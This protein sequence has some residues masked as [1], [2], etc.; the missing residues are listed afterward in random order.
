MLVFADV[1]LP[2]P[3]PKPFTYEVPESLQANLM[4]G[5]RVV[6]PFGKNKFYTGLVYRIHNQTPVGYEAKPI[7]SV[8]ESNPTVTDYQF[9]LWEWITSYYLCPLGLIMKAALPSVL[10]LESQTILEKNEDE[11]LDWSALSEE[12][13]LL[14]EALEQGPLTFSDIMAITGKKAVMKSIGGLLAKNT[15]RLQQVLKD[16]YRPKL[17]KQLR[18]LPT[19]LQPSAL[20]TIFEQLKKAPKQ[21]E[22]LM[23][24]LSMHPKGGWTDVVD[25]QKKWGSTAAITQQLVK[26]SIFEKRQ[27]T[28]DRLQTEAAEEKGTQLVLTPP[29]KDAYEAIQ[30]SFERHSVVLLEGITGS[31]KT[32]VYMEQIRATMT[33]GK[34]VLYL[35]PEISL[36]TQIVA[37]L[38]AQFP[39][40]I[41]VFHSKFNPQERTEIWRHILQKDN[42]AQL[43]V[44]ARSAVLLPFQNL[45]LVIIDEEH[46]TAYKQ[47]DPAPRYHARDSA[48]VMAQYYKAKVLLGSATPSLESL[49]QVQKGKYGHVSL[50]QRYGGAQLPTIDLVDVKEA[51]RKKQMQLGMF[52]DTLVSAIA[53][54]LEKE[55]QVILFHNRR[56]YAPLLECRT[57][58]HIPQCTQCDVSLTYHQ[59]NPRMQC[60]YC[61]YQVPKPTECSACGTPHLM[62]KGT[63][64][65]QI[66]TALQ[67]L[68]PQARIGRMD[69]DSTRGKNDFDTLLASFA[70]GKIQVL[71]GTQMVVKGLDFKNVQLVG[72]INADQLINQ[73]DFRAFERS[74]QMLSQV[75]GRAGRSQTPGRVLIQ[76]Y[77]PNQPLLQHVKKQS[78]GAFYSSELL[79][80]KRLMYPPFGRLIRLTFKHRNRDLVEK[81]ALWFA[82]VI[83][84]SYTQPILGPAAPPIS[85]IQNHYLQQVLFKMTSPKDRKQLKLLL[86][87]TQRSFESIAQYR[88]VKI[89]MDVDPY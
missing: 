80:R 45:G 88:A 82:N 69:W 51:Y 66:E 83:R 54:V 86:V 60:H 89:N 7:D 40:R 57:C 5:Q 42:K 26:K 34:Q 59:F 1:I 85:R 70:T 72:V 25:L 87:K 32:A 65:Q 9:S 62:D 30:K 61:G 64:T 15:V 31:G 39:D 22:L 48:I 8:L 41:A 20:D 67:E 27:I 53:S 81:A 29:Q 18:L 10:L 36:T 17:K 2:I 50:R 4:R 55:Q 44:G 47:F 28:V 16:T 56:G 38:K 73:P 84:Q 52:T 76:T 19:L 14:M 37:R 21:Q 12:E 6:V 35:L 77:N 74:I 11:V 75:A 46:E 33:A 3:L 23:G 43:L 24:Y 79:E 58:G 63:G 78:L 49:F 68:F 13:H 71:V